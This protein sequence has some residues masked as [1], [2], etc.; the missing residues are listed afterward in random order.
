MTTTGPAA[1]SRSTPR[2]TWPPPGCAGRPGGGRRQM[3]IMT[4]LTVGAA[5]TRTST[6]PHRPGRCP[7][8]AAAA[9][10]GADVPHRR[11]RAPR[12]G[13]PRVIRP[14]VPDPDADQHGH[15]ADPAPAGPDGQRLPA[16]ARGPAETRCAAEGSVGR[17]RRHD[18]ADHR[19][20][21]AVQ[22][23]RRRHRVHPRPDRHPLRGR[24]RSRRQGREDHR[25]DPEHRLR[26]RHRQRPAAGADPRQVRGRV[27]RCRTPTARWSG[28]A[29]CS[30][31]P[32]RGP[33]TTRW[34]SG[35]A[36][37]SRATS[38][39]PTWPRP[40][41]CWWPARPVPASPAS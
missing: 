8:A 28:S 6:R 39:P 38:S 20:P 25:A 26:G 35:S 16:A 14:A 22:R 21:R 10:A 2:P 15:R 33:I 12:V 34:S 23:G 30:P 13:Q 24:T 27:S 7:P 32:A 5:A 17:E 36:R 4:P 19:R 40:R 1:R 37:T 3:P 29:T 31:R 11:A 41:I 9:A 18:R